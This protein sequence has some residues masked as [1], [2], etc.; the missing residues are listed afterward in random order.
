[1]DGDEDAEGDSLDAAGDV[2]E[3]VAPRPMKRKSSVSSSNLSKRPKSRKSSTGRKKSSAEP[4]E[5][6]DWD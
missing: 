1:M 3:T 5:D 4:D 6:L 2:D